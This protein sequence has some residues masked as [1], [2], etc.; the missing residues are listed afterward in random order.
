[1]PAEDGHN[2]FVS[3]ALKGS[4]HLRG[5]VPD[6]A[7]RRDQGASTS[8]EEPPGRRARSLR[9][10]R[11]HDAN[12]TKVAQGLGEDSLKPYDA[13]QA[14]IGETIARPRGRQRQRRRGRGRRQRVS[15]GWPRFSASS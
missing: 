5:E 3:D 2:L 9:S 12:I 8:L 11:E 14:A 13:F 7:P 10:E 4:E 6:H 1:M 15:M